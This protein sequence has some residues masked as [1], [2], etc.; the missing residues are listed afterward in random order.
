[1][2]HFVSPEIELIVMDVED[3]IVTS[4]VEVETEDPRDE[5]PEDEW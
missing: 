4:P 2:K 1:M 3:I 5:L